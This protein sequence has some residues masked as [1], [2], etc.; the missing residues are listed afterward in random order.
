MEHDINLLCIGYYGVK[1][2]YLDK[3]SDGLITESEV[4]Q[5]HE[6]DAELG[7]SKTRLIKNIPT[8]EFHEIWFLFWKAEPFTDRMLVIILV[9]LNSFI[10]TFFDEA[11]FRGAR[12]CIL[13]V[14][15][16]YF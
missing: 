8:E 13:F 7:S 4:H 12:F 5:M 1:M 14:H 10:G 11:I 16:M 15:P 9:P 3:L 6:K 2:P